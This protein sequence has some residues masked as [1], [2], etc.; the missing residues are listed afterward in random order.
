M[1]D[2]HLTSY[3]VELKNNIEFLD[4]ESDEYTHY[5]KYI[6][7]ETKVNTEAEKLL[8]DKDNS[9]SESLAEDKT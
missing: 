6:E 1:D 3:I 5:E 9:S 7:D 8:D 2:I 4:V